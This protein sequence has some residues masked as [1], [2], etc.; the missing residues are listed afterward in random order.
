MNGFTQGDHTTYD[1]N[2]RKDWQNWQSDIGLS[3]A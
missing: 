3:N 1:K 2:D